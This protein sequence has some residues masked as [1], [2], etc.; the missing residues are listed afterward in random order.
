MDQLRYEKWAN[1]LWWDFIRQSPDP[2]VYERAYRHLAGCYI[3]WL[4]TIGPYPRI[5]NAALALPDDL[6]RAYQNLA[7]VIQTSAPDASV[8][9]PWSDN[10]QPCLVRDIVLHTMLHGMYHRGHLRTIAEAR[11]E[12]GWP[13]TDWIRWAR[14]GREQTAAA[15]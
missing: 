3:G 7:E 9:I 11:G 2:T 14:F 8:V 10:P 12:T 6:D 1:Q 5:D 15:E 4:T 13:E